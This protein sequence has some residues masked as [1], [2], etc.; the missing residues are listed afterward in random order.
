MHLKLEN[1]NDYYLRRPEPGDAEELYIQKNDP[2][3][4]VLLGGFGAGLSRRDLDEWLEFHRR[5]KEEVVWSVVEET[6]ER[7]VGHAG[8]YKIDHRVGCAE[9]GIMIGDKTL[10]GSGLGRSVVSRVLKFSWEELNLRRIQLNVLAS[11]E[12]A[13]RLYKG[14]GFFEEGKLREAQFKGGQYVDVVL[15]GILRESSGG[16]R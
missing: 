16:T 1:R 7:C 3:V 6:S 8:L 10:W 5:C 2:E 11:N 15:M 12:R 4:A 9:F 14:C 13:I